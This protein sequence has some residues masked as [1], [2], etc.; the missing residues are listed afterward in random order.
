MSKPTFKPFKPPGRVVPSADAAGAAAPLRSPAAAT[1]PAACTALPPRVDGDE[2]PS[3]VTAV[4][5]PPAPPARSLAPAAPPCSA[6]GPGFQ[7][8]RASWA[9]P[10]AASK[11]GGSAAAAAP[12][13]AYYR[14]TY[15]PRSGKKQRCGTACGKACAPRLS[16]E[17]LLRRLTPRLLSSSWLKKFVDGVLAVQGGD[18]VTL[19]SD[20][21]KKVAAARV[22]GCEAMPPDATLELGSWD[23]EVGE[24]LGEAGFLSGAVFLKS[25]AAAACGGVAAGPSSAAPQPRAPLLPHPQPSAPFRAVGGGG[26]AAAPAAAPR[27]LH[28]PCAPSPHQHFPPLFSFSPFSLTRNNSP[29]STAPGALVLSPASCPRLRAIGS[30]TRVAV[31]VDPYLS[32]R[33]RPHQKE[34]VQFMY[35]CVSGLRAPGHAGCLLCDDSAWFVRPFGSLL[36]SFKERRDENPCATCVSCAA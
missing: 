3:A 22:R 9:A 5:P 28:D 1:A 35:D 17:R 13:D 34:G 31:V 2:A 26:A 19:F 32:S 4:P 25:V 12:P 29:H 11:G 33:L 18:R 16:S 30:P 10:G 14:V 27:S 6:G 23:V 36:F 7:A 15:C 20:E 8:P 21:G 24:T